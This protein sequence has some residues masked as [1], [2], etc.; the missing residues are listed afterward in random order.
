MWCGCMGMSM[1]HTHL[2]Y[3]ATYHVHISYLMLVILLARTCCSVK[4]GICHVMGRFILVLMLLY[5]ALKT[6][7]EGLSEIM[8]TKK[9]KNDQLSKAQCSKA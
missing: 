9:N 7:V 2:T 6:N 8:F 5:E 4:R 1:H 3:N